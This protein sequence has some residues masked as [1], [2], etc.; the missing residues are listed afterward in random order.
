[1]LVR[2]LLLIGVFVGSAV[3]TWAQ[4]LANP[5]APKPITLEKIVAR[6][7][8]YI[9]LKSELDISVYQY[10]AQ[11]KEANPKLPAPDPAKVQCQLLEQLVM[12]KIL[13]AKSDIDS[14]TVKDEEVTAELDERMAYMIQQVGGR[15][16]LEAYYKKSVEQFKAE[17]RKQVREQLIARKMQGKITE[18]VKVTPAQ[19][20]RYF[21]AIP[22]DSIPFF[23][24]EV[25]VAQIVRHFK[26]GRVRKQEAKAKAED[27]RKKI[28]EGEDFEIM[29]KLYSAD[30]GSA[31][32]GGKLLG[33]TRGQMVPEYEAAAM[34]LKKGE[35]SPVTESQFGFHIIQILDKR[36]NEYDSRHILIQPTASDEDREYA[37]KFLDS[38]GREIRRDS[39]TFE[40]AAQKFSDDQNSK[41]SGGFFTDP[42]SGSTRVPTEALDP[43]VFF[44][45]DTMKIG[46]VSPPISYQG[47]DGKLGYR[48]L[49][50]KSK[51]LPHEANLQD[52][53]QRI[54]AGALGVAKRKA[55]AAWLKKARQDVSIHLEP[56]YKDCKIL[57]EIEN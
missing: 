38:L 20:R 31:Q 34:Q 3:C 47:E 52:D 44:V 27:L 37:F 29:A 57:Q 11:Y 14:V 54:Q 41:S 49:L 50:Y 2:F 25:E 42:S 45:I 10:M 23:S 40:V 8:G 26:P 21:N 16:R 53:Y 36:G 30:P 48:I 32:L 19:V 43:K 28:L 46:G 9:L 5:K 51:V 17:L 55:T 7:D 6:A 56:E 39:I 33:A 22:K 15:D 1:M 4:P 18:E 24:T 13:L 12:Q 35:T